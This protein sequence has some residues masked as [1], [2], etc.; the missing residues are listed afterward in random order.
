MKHYLVGLL[1]ALALWWAYD[2]HYSR[3]YGRSAAIYLFSETEVKG[4]DGKPLSRAD[5][6]DMMIQSALEKSGT[7][8]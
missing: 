2:Y 1:T 7:K 8:E 3:L 4:A 5:I 6:I